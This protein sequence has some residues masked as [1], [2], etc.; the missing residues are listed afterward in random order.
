MPFYQVLFS[1]KKQSS[2]II[3]I[4]YIMPDLSINNTLS[5]REHEISNTVLLGYII[6]H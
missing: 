6:L 1:D 5:K 2:F 3:W 4:E